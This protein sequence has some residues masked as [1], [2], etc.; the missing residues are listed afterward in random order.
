MFIAPVDASRRRRRSG[1]PS[2]RPIPSATWSHRAG[3]SATC[4]SSCP[5]SS[6]SPATRCGCISCG[7]I[8]CSRAL[9]ENPRVLLSVADDWAFIPSAWK[10]IGDEDPTLGIPTT[11]YGRC[12]SSAR[13]G[14]T[15]SGRRPGRWPRSCGASWRCSNPTSTWPTRARP[16]RR[17]CAAILGIEIR[18]ERVSA[19]FK[20]GGNVDAGAPAGRGGA[21]RGIRGRGGRRGR[22]RPG[23]AP[24]G[25]LSRLLGRRRPGWP[26]SVSISL[27]GV[28]GAVVAH[29]PRHGHE[30]GLAL[31]LART[32]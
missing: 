14:C 27:L 5:P 10:A 16:T 21:A 22:G 9:A 17:S 30:P 23:R 7:R 6:C 20:Y 1:A 8:R 25:A 18:V 29:D 3:P 31:V 11:Y 4:P 12:N 24:V 13:R 28:R 26:A 2:S 19:K 15:T 32:R